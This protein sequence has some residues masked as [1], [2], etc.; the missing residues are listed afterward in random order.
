[1][2]NG[3]AKAAQDGMMDGGSMP[4]QV[5]PCSDME[6]LLQFRGGEW[7][8]PRVDPEWADPSRC[9]QLTPTG[10]VVWV[11]TDDYGVPQCL[12]ALQNGQNVAALGALETLHLTRFSSADPPLPKGEVT[13]N[14]WAF[15]VCSL[16]FWYRKDAS[17]RA[18][19][20]PLRAM[21][22]ILSASWVPPPLLKQFGISLIL[23][24]VYG[25][26]FTFD[27]KMQG[28]YR[29]SQG[30][31]ESVAH[32]VARLEGK[33]NDIQVKHPS[34]VSEAETTGYIREHLFYGLKKPLQEAIHAKFES[35][36]NVYMAL[37][38]ATREAKGEHE[39]EKLNTSSVSRLGVV[40]EGQSH[41]EG[42][43]NH[44]CGTPT[45]TPWSTWVAGDPNCRAPTAT[46][47]WPK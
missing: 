1:M 29:A 44:D 12:Q 16:Q 21:Q 3:S 17:G 4:P 30:R 22:P 38:R 39:H 11:Q 41:P 9:D 19:S 6:G 14:H 23:C 47:A 10:P 35:P 25:L 46:M 33:L 2:W 15:E 40:S 13:Y 34:W 5:C 24:M 18:L 26:V 28:F 31:S 8:A 36:S 42:S 32:Y 7:V 20:D 27:I 43:A 37:I 45:Q